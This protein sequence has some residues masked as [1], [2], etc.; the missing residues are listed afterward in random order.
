MCQI[1]SSTD[2][3]PSDCP[4]WHP[5]GGPDSDD[6][7]IAESPVDEEIPVVR[8]TDNTSPPSDPIPS[9]SPQLIPEPD[10]RPQRPR[11]TVADVMEEP[12]VQP[13]PDASSGSPEKDA[14][15]GDVT[16][17]GPAELA[18]PPQ[19]DLAVPS[20]EEMEEGEISD[21]TITSKR[22]RE[23]IDST[24]SSSPSLIIDTS[25]DTTDV[26]AK[27]MAKKRGKKKKKSS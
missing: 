17:T 15:S 26:E 20:E 22:S 3:D 13:V 1:C 11:E 6:E 10:A 12:V 5:Y 25:E 24:S 18:S 27:D 14:A 21:A 2:H 7:E 9:L 19:V 4:D 8:E 23:E 16:E